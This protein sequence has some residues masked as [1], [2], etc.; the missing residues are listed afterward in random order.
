MAL[1]K[2]YVQALKEKQNGASNS[3]TQR[4]RN[5]YHMDVRPSHMLLGDYQDLLLI[6]WEMA[7]KH[8]SNL[9]PGPGVAG[10]LIYIHMDGLNIMFSKPGWQSVPN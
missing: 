9:W 6:G 8:Y 7:T 10:K 2:G 3:S 5:A 4:N 1:G